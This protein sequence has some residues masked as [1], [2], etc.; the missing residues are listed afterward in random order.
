MNRVYNLEHQSEPV[1]NKK[2]LCRVRSVVIKRQPSVTD[3][4]ISP[5]SL[6]EKA[7]KE[8]SQLKPGN[9]SDEIERLE[10][11]IRFPKINDREYD[12]EVKGDDFILK[13]YENKNRL[14]LV[15][16]VREKCA[17]GYMERR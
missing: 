12:M 8:I 2:P 17:G 11:L 7:R 15:Y 1:S 16:Q 4:P 14:E 13:Y 5:N 9:N 10:S 6:W 3:T